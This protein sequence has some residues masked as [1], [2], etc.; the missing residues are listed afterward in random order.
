[1]VLPMEWSRI[2]ARSGAR[3]RVARVEEAAVEEQ[4]LGIEQVERGGETPA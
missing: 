2:D 3:T 4:E 1:M